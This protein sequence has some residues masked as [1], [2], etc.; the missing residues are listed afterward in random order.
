MWQRGA[1]GATFTVTV[2]GGA[3]PVHYVAIEIVGDGQPGAYFWSQDARG[4]GTPYVMP[5]PTRSGRFTYT[6]QVVDE[7]GCAASTVGAVTVAP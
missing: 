2:T 7:M 5:V 1:V 4:A 3:T 6:V